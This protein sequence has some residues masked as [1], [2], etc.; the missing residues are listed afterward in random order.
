MSHPAEANPDRLSFDDVLRTTRSVRRRF[1]LNRPVEIELIRECLEL[2]LQAPSGSNAQGWR[3]LLIQDAHKRARLAEMYRVGFARYR[4]RPDSLLADHG[5]ERLADSV[6]YLAEHLHEVPLH[7]IPCISGRLTADA[8]DSARAAFMAS[9]IPA[10]WSF[11]LACRSRGLGTCWTTMHLAQERRAARLLDIPY[12]DVTQ[13]ALIPIGHTIGS[14]F[15]PAA[16]SRLERAA[17]INTWSTAW[18]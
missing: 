8:P 4:A 7:L 6:A 9:I 1:D 12:D 2:A 10:T 13:I 14:E 11:M 18:S 17:A 3:F 16:R 5:H 15:R